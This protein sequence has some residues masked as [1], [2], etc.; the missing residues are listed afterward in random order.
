MA[1]GKTALRSIL[2]LGR[3]ARLFCGGASMSAVVI[4]NWKM[5]GALTGIELFAQQWQGFD[6]PH[7]VQAVI[8]PPFVYLDAL[9]RLMPKTV[10]LGAQDCSAHA[11]GA[12]TG[13]IAADML[14]ELGCDWVILGHSERRVYQGEDDALIAAKAVQA[15]TAGLSAVVCVGEHLEQRQSGE[16]QAV[17]AAQLAGSLSGVTPENLVIAYEPVWAIGTGQSATP[18]QAQAMHRWIRSCL[19]QHFGAASEQIAVIYGGSVKPE[20][21]AELFDCDTIDGAL[22]GGASLE[23]KSFGEIVLAAA[24]GR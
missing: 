16:H 4:A 8:C 24:S 7:D 14:V 20:T 18:A 6:V 10:Q 13:D 19:V 5:N 12:Y 1:P 21:A 17:V 3:L 15:Q 11:D 2:A 23:A 22:V 9:R